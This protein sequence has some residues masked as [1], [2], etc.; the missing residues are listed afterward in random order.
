MQKPPY[1]SPLPSVIPFKTQLFHGLDDEL[2]AE[3]LSFLSPRSIVL[4]YIIRNVGFEAINNKGEI[5]P[6]FGVLQNIYETF[7]NYAIEAM[8]K[9]M[10]NY[11]NNNELLQASK[12]LLIN[13]LLVFMK[14]K[15]YGMPLWADHQLIRDIISLWNNKLAV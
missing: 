7:N 1:S 6:F 2:I 14:T 10:I 3:I 15:K 9:N 8:Q 4:N 13:K 11:Y 5:T 12:K